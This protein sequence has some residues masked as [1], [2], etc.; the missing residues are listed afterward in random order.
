MP[1]R[2]QI[3]SSS[4]MYD[5]LLRA[6]IKDLINIIYILAYLSVI[7]DPMKIKIKVLLS[8]SNSLSS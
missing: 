7:K 5:F 1:G 3:C 4:S 8:H 6:G 2:K